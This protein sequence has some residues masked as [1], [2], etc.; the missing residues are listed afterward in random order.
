MGRL[1]RFRGDSVINVNANTNFLEKPGLR[2]IA[3]LLMDPEISEIMING[4]A[5][6]V[7]RRG[8]MQQVQSPFQSAAQL[9]VLVDNLVVPSG[10]AVN[11]RSPF[12]DLRIPDG[13]RVNIVVAPAALDG[14]IIT[15]RKVTRTLQTLEDLV[16]RGTLT[17]KMAWFLCAAIR[18]RLNILFCGGTATGK[19]TTLSML[20]AYID[21][22]E[23]IVVVEDTAELD[24]RQPHVVRMECRPAT[25]EVPPVTL[26]DLVTNSLRMR[27]T[28]IILGEIR[29]EEAFDMVNAMSTGHDGCLAVVHAGTPAHAVARMEMMMLSRGIPLPMWAIQR[30]IAG[31]LHLIVQQALLPDG[32]RRITH[33]TAVDGVKDDIIQLK[34]LFE[35]NPDGI[36]AEGHPA[37]F[38]ASGQKPVFL[39]K[40][41]RVAGSDVV[42][43]LER[44]VA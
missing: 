14:P 5:L 43:V 36:D 1:L 18:S 41:T 4:R 22:S 29:G 7:E 34:H 24:L 35:F 38:S 32:T 10:R 25:H 20:S 21:P 17:Q 16:G 42:A 44:G 3:H 2:P 39:D 19:T 30:Q 28:R 37:Q 13:S 31:A 6:F 23:R 33:I 40:M 12:V 11:A 26:K 27:P 8:R 9:D 15:I